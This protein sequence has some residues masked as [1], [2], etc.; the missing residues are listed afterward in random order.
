MIMAG[1]KLKRI[2]LILSAL[3]LSGCSLVSQHEPSN[4]GVLY[5]GIYTFGFEVNA[6]SP[7]DEIY[8]YWLYSENRALDEIDKSLM[9][10]I[11][12]S[13]GKNPYPSIYIEFYGHQEVA[14]PIEHGEIPSS[15]D[16]IINV[17]RLVKTSS[18]EENP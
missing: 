13:D 18:I 8:D 4:E 16:A 9:N 15:Y 12:S 11:V 1:K 14:S 17:L 5:K 3:V 10:T 6:F 2:L 7:N